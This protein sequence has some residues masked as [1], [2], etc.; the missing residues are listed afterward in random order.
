MD[1]N[2]LTFKVGG[3][4]YTLEDIKELVTSEKAKDEIDTLYQVYLK[5]RTQTKGTIEAS[6]FTMIRGGATQCVAY[7]DRSIENIEKFTLQGDLAR[8]ILSWLGISE[9]EYK[10]Y[11]SGGSK[12]VSKFKEEK[13]QEARD[14]GVDE[15]TIQKLF[16]QVA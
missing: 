11:R 1:I 10:D 16:G 8:S 5:T 13:I 6:L 15:D 14:L 2:T 9:D 4:E 7:Q 3:D 12:A